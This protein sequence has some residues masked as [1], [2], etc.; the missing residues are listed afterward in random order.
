MEAR[1][2]ASYGRLF[3]KADRQASA[4]IFTAWAQRNYV[5]V[6]LRC[7]L[8]RNANGRLIDVVTDDG[9][10]SDGASLAAL[11]VRWPQFSWNTA[12][13]WE[14]LTGSRVENCHA[15]P[16]NV[17]PKEWKRLAGLLPEGR[18]YGAS[19]TPGAAMLKRADAREALS[20]RYGFEGQ[21][22]R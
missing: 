15:A 20:D 10:G 17:T 18:E 9:R 21:V 7:A 13:D 16:V 6:P 11:N 12:R 3:T 8:V 19:A 22:N 1:T 14:I 4:I 2:T 5:T